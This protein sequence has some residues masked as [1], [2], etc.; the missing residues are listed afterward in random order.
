MNLAEKYIDDLLSGKV[1]AGPYIIK[2]FQRHRRDLLTAK[3]RSIYFD[4]AAGQFVI[5]FIQEFC[6]PAEQD[7]PLKLTPWQHAVLYISYGWKRA[8]GSRRFRRLYI[9]IA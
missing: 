3:D 8:D 6:I 7:V 4:P 1:P 2:A 9:E 5:D